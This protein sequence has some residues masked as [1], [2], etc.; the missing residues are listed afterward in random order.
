MEKVGILLNEIVDLLQED[1]FSD[2]IEIL[3][4][5]PWCNKTSYIKFTSPKL[6]S[7][8]VVQDIIVDGNVLKF[9]NECDI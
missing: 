1:T 4:K 9:R 3:S 6:S 2:Q 8:R 5:T 7:G